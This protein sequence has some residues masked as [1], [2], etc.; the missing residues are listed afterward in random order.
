MST[1]TRPKAKLH[2]RNPH[3]GRYDFTALTR[4]LPALASYTKA[5]P[6]GEPTID[7]SDADAVRT[8]NKALLCQYYQVAFWELPEGY[9]CPPIPGRA[10]YMHHIADL[11]ADTTHQ[12]DAGTPP[13]GKQIHALDIGTG[14]SCIYPIIG[15]QSYGWRFTATDVDPISVQT[16]KVIVQ[17]NPALKNAIKVKQ[18]TQPEHIFKGII[19][20]QDYFDITLCN[21]PFQG[22]LDEAMNA[23]TRKRQK[24]SRHQQK[25]GSTSASNSASE[26]DA[27]NFGGQKKELWIAGGEIG[28]LRQMINESVEVTAHVGWFTTLVSKSDNLR[29]LKKLLQEVNA[30]DVRVIDMTHGQKIT[31]IL[32]WRFP[33]PSE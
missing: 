5:N 14:A 22:S 12:N 30:S 21:P 32:A 1:P 11:L 4:A 25:R 2:P 17:A 6:S 19:G 20:R 29:P 15:A 10:D 28:F 18:Q 33:D 13:T 16:A 8:L 7:F 3:Q 31:R 9:L 24:L 23:N 27:L 26:S